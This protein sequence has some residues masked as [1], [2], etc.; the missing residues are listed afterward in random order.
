MIINT[1]N[2]M[3]RFAVIA[4]SALMGLMLATGIYAANP[5]SVVAEVEFVAP[6]TI[7]EDS[8]M[9]FGLLDVNLASLETIIL[10]PDDSTS[11]TGTS[12]ILGSAPLAADLTITA[13]ASTGITI[14]VDNVTTGTG[15]GLGTWMCEYDALGPLACDGAGWDV[16]SVASGALRVGV[17]LTG[18][19]TAVVGNQDGSFDVTVSYQ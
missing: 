19:G 16:T 13:S 1:S 7:A 17:T 6:V 8:S 14:L 11:G 4:G 3:K 15:Y 18:D 9:Q 5:E 12:R 10:A 2:W